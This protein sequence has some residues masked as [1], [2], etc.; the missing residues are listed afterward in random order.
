M[1]ALDFR[2]PVP[3]EDT[4][5]TRA[6]AYEFLIP[7]RGV[8]VL[9]PGNEQVALFRLD[10]GTLRAVGNIDPFMNAAVMSRGIVGDRKGTPVVASPLLKQAFSLETGACLD[11]ES[12]ALPVYD[13]RISEGM[14]EV[15]PADPRWRDEV[16]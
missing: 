13:V 7:N 16:A 6:C 10:D 9:L 8:A 11:D 2:Q 5:W 4:A 15:R 12:M 3:G 1:T 14:V